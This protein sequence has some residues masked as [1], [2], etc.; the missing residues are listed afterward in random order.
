MS[1]YE[2]KPFSST[3]NSVLEWDVD[4]VARWVTT[5]GLGKYA[6]YF[7]DNNITGDVLVYLNQRD[8]GE[9]GI[10]SVGHRLR[11]LKA[12][13]TI[14]KSQNLDIKDHYVPPKSQTRDFTANLNQILKSFETRDERMSLDEQEIRKLGESFSKLREDLLPIYRIVKESKPLP[15][16]DHYTRST[17][18]P[19][20]SP[21]YTASQVIRKVSSKRT[22]HSQPQQSQP[23]QQVQQQ[24]QQ[25]QP[26]SPKRNSQDWLDNSFYNVSSSNVSIM[27]K[28]SAA[29][30]SASNLSSRS[31]PTLT[32]Q[33][34]RGVS[35]NSSRAPSSSAASIINSSIPTNASSVSFNVSVGGSMHSD[36]I[37]DFNISPDVPCYKILPQIA[38]R[39]KVR[40]DWRGVGLVVCYDDQERMIGLEEK[41]LAIYKELQ[42]EGKNP[43]FMIREDNG[44]KTDSGFVVNG[45]PGGLL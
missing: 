20:P 36:P 37:K 45:T 29:T 27:S 26:H 8:L 1:Y 28:D 38:R 2:E 41:P 6:V 4:S 11:I 32:G 31:M 21:T 39:H 43:I 42:R 18:P 9:I 10:H 35:T 44:L 12:I 40:G 34:Q 22:L 14:I 30:I 17:T 25:Q 33:S 16:P 5:L 19:V 13:Y 24:Q 23:P 3:A 15:T 7:Q